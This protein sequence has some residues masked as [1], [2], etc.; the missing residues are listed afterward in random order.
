[1]WFARRNRPKSET[2]L[3]CGFGSYVVSSSKGPRSG[4]GPLTLTDLLP[5]NPRAMDLSE[6]HA[7]IIG[8]SHDEDLNALRDRWFERQMANLVTPPPP[9]PIGRPV[10]TAVGV[11][12]NQLVIAE[13]MMVADVIEADLWDDHDGT[14]QMSDENSDCVWDEQ[15]LEGFE[16][17]LE[18]VPDDNHPESIP[19]ALPAIEFLN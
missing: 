2:A 12:Y 8:A 5:A 15:D 17:E 3:E 6:L 7:L 1:M 16:T 9:T 10:I 4:R 13:P 18:H 19:F 14:V 11:N